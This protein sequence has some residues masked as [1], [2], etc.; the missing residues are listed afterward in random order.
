MDW[1]TIYT[2]LA[3]NRNQ[4][5]AWSALESRVRSWAQ[6]Q[7]RRLPKH[8]IDDVVADTCSGVAMGF[9]RCRGADT[10]NGFV[11]GFYLNE[12]RRKLVETRRAAER[13]DVEE[14]ELA[15][16][17]PYCS[18]VDVAVLWQALAELPPRVRAAV[19]LRYMEGLP[20]KDIA[21]EL[22]VTTG[23]ARQIVHVG[24]GLLRK[25]LAAPELRHASPAR[26]SVAAR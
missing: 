22:G 2:E 9:E 19:S 5:Q 26:P 7:L 20:A 8:A 13:R 11:Y 4:P 15:G 16:P 25:R 6:G 3:S 24:L 18:D 12:R 21:R 14:I 1:T 23:N 10:F 17:T